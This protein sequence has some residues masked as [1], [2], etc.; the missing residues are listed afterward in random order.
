MSSPS[1]PALVTA[2]AWCLG[3]LSFSGQLSAAPCGRPDVDVT[4]PP[5]GATDVPVNAKLS[6]HYGSPALYLDEP[7]SL[8]DDSGAAIDIAVHYDEA[9]S[10]LYAE[11]GAPLATGHYQLEWPELRSVS[12]G[13]VGLGASVGFFVQST[14]DAAP[15]R[16][17]GLRGIDWDLARDEDPCSD[18]LEDRFV[19]T[20]GLGEASDDADTELLSVLV[21]QTQQPGSSSGPTQVALRGFPENGKL[22]LRRPADDAGSTCFAAVVQDLIGNVS[23]GGDREV[24]VKTKSPPFFDGC[25]VAAAKPAVSPGALGWL[26]WA[27]L[28]GLRRR[29]ARAGRH[30]QRI[31]R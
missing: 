30:P 22:E 12:T 11:P 15:P 25:S 9:Q 23:D 26:P 16:F 10:L 3:A 6:A 31:A 8:V 27:L 7:V 5:N 4:F 17:A 2:A 14:T 20:L 28:A 18:Q 13:G 24:C 29:G 19:F 1:K 21:F